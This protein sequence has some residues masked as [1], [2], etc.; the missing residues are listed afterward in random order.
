MKSVK[1]GRRYYRGAVVA[2]G[3]LA[4]A[5]ISPLHTAVAAERSATQR[6]DDAAITAQ[7]KTRLLADEVTRSININVDTE[8]GVVT[9]RGTAPTAEAKA[10]AEQVAKSVEGVQVVANSLIVGDS[11]MNPQTVTAKAK[12]VAEE[13]EH[14]AGD[15]WITT[16][17]KAQLLADSD[18][19]GLD[20]N[21]STKDGVV[22]LAGMVPSK[23]VR[24][25]AISIAKGVKGVKSVNS[26]AL[27]AK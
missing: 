19:K 3:F 1:K 6:V 24:D 23:M 18:I 26:D 4:V 8:A 13:G 9:L 20:I 12:E 2:T 22:T 21:V 17:V 27:K 16:K 7:V 25:K 15:A 14:A 5:A 10:K 11:S